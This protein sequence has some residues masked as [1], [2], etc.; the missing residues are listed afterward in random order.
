[1]DAEQPEESR[2]AALRTRSSHALSMFT[3]YLALTVAEGKLSKVHM[4]SSASAVAATADKAAA[5]ARAA[6]DSL[7]EKSCVRRVICSVPSN[8]RLATSGPA[9]QDQGAELDPPSDA[10]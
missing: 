1:M 9:R 3:P 5:A 7:M 8:P 6:I 2:T 10:P 4:P